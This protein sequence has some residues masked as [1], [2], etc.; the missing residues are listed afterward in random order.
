MNG[1]YRL[2]KGRE[3]NSYR[4]TS[5]A[6]AIPCGNTQ[7]IGM[8]MIDSAIWCLIKSDKELLKKVIDF[9]EPD[10]IIESLD[11]AELRFIEKFKL[12]NKFGKC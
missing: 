2:S 6:S 10:K 12:L 11:I 1:N 8:L 3:A 5:R 4:C 9:Y 7:S